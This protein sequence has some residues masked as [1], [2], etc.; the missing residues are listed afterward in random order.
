MYLKNNIAESLYLATGTENEVLKIITNLKNS[1][2]G[3]NELM[4]DIV[5]KIKECIVIP[6]LMSVMPL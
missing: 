1:A 5:K 3:L 6:L 2:A 4:A